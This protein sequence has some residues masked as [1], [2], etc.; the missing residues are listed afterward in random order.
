MLNIRGGVVLEKSDNTE[1][2]SIAMQ[3]VSTL[4][5]QHKRMFLCW[6]ITFIVL[7]CLVVYIVYL[8]NDM[9]VVETT[10]IMQESEGNNYNTIKNNGEI[11]YG[12]T[13][14]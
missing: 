9:A 5:E 7:T 8:L 12:E 13:K 6:L 11:V 1:D 3:F 4:K 2:K 10:E 14:D